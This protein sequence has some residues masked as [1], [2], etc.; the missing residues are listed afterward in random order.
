MKK[1]VSTLVFKKKTISHLQ[2]N[3]KGG[4]PPPRDTEYS[5]CQIPEEEEEESGTLMNTLFL[6]TACYSSYC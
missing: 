5:S 4:T 3:L 2:Y 6:S 1:K